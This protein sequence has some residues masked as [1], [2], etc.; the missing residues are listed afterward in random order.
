MNWRLQS[1]AFVI[2]LMA[3][4][5][6]SADTMWATPSAGAISVTGTLSNPNDVIEYTFNVSAASNVSLQS[7]SYGGGTNAAGQT[8]SAG[9]FEIGELA[10][11]GPAS[12][13]SQLL[14]EFT[15]G[16]N[17]G[18]GA[19]GAATD[20]SGYC[21]DI[22]GTASLAAGT[23]TVALTAFANLTNGLSLADG[24]TGGGDFTTNGDTLNPDYAFDITGQNVSPVPEPATLLML[25]SGLVLASRKLRKRAR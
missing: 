6:C 7:F 5:Y 4:S 25:G 24:F 21:G 20:G 2:L 17:L 1:L 13:G 9:G 22:A 16:T 23:Y 15:Q 11:F 10:L 14:A 3:C 8:I 18:C 12:G 19:G